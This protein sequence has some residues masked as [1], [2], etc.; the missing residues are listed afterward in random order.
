MEYTNKKR[1]IG[2]L[3]KKGNKVYLLRKN[4]KTKRPSNKLDFKKL[5]PFEIIEKI[6]SINFKL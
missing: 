6:G 2:P 5:G 1:I 3:L 4:I